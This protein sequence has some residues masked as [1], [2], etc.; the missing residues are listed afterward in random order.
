MGSIAGALAGGIILGLTENLLGYYGGIAWTSAAGPL[1]I[2]LILLVRPNG[3][4]G[5][6]SADRA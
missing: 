5:R 1:V 4:F 2:A 3:L 6:K